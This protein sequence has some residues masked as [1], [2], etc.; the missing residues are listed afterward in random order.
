MKVF[1]SADIE[2]TCGITDW[3]ETERCTMD[4][5]KPFQ[6]QMT[7]EV[8]AACKGALD[9]GVGEIFLKDAHDSARN[10]DAAELPECIRI[11]RGW[12]GDPL[13]MMSGLDR[14]DYGAVLFTGYHAWASCPGN[15]LSHTMNLR[16][17]HVL[18]NGVRASEFLINAYTAGYYGV[19][20]VFLSGD[21]ELCAFAREFIPEIVTVPVN[22]GVGGGVISIHPDVAVSQGGG[23]SGRQVQGAHAGAVRQR[24]PIPGAPDGL[25]QELLPRGAAGRWKECVLLHRRLV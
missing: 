11:L 5:Y 6:K 16:N 24:D 17:E 7:R 10:I 4:D 8:K 21:E 14:D 20:A 1:I 12:T 22:R 19:P 9:A 3:A 15:P 18:L 2:G 13:S 23:A 25:L